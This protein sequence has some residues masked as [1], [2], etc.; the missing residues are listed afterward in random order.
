MFLPR[1]RLAGVSLPDSSSPLPECRYDP[2]DQLRDDFFRGRP[3]INEIPDASLQ[4][5][6]LQW[7]RLA[8]GEDEKIKAKNQGDGFAY[9]RGLHLAN[10]LRSA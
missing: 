1:Q 6:L 10:S 3:S 7:L 8:A 2:A 9:G 4:L 5:A